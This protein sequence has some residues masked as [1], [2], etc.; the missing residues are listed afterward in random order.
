MKSIW[1]L[2]LLL[3]CI[4]SNSQVTLDNV[5]TPSIGI[6]EDFY[7]VQISENETKYL[8]EDTLMNTFS[9]YN[10]DFTPFMLNISVPEPFAR[11]FQVIY[12]TKTLFDCD[13]TNI[14]YVYQAA[15]NGF[16]SFYIM[17]TDGTQIFKLDSASGPFCAGSC[18]GFSD[19][20][21]PIKNTSAGAKL[22][23]QRPFSAYNG[24]IFIYSLCGTLPLNI[25]DF[26]LQRTS[27]VTVFPNPTSKSLTFRIIFPDNLNNYELVIKDILGRE[28]ENLNI[29]VGKSE[30]TIEMSQYDNG[31][32]FYSFCNQ[33]KTYQTGKFL[34]IK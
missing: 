24:K 9:L 31:T 23:L 2:L 12:V 29:N 33:N 16:K 10:M 20:I 5:V 34:L 14:E 22:F 26:T 15:I 3:I 11:E 7:T 13:S 8:F 6:G 25:L 4:S 32:Y 18:L 28:V 19:F 1:T 27:F 21:Q 30:Y 17:R